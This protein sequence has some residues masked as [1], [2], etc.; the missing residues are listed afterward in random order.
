MVKTSFDV[1]SLSQEQVW[2]FSVSGNRIYEMRCL[3]VG[4]MDVDILLKETK[5]SYNNHMIMRQNISQYVRLY[6]YILI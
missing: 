3:F 1:F 6:V 2:I 5:R 4:I